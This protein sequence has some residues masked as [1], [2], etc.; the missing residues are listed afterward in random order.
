MSHKILAM[1]Q[2]SNCMGA[3]WVSILKIFIQQYILEWTFVIKHGLMFVWHIIYEYS[4]VYNTILRKYAVWLCVMEL[5]LLSCRVIE[6]L[7]SL[8][9][10][11]SNHEI[12]SRACHMRLSSPCLY[13]YSYRKLST[14]H[15]SPFDLWLLGLIL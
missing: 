7:K 14:S 8:L 6:V 15:S 11:P 2:Y 12:P 4:C 3:K 9:L 10:I 5:S 13:T 1:F